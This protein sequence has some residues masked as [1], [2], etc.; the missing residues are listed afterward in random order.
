MKNVYVVCNVYTTPFFGKASRIKRI[1][2][3]PTHP[4]VHSI[5]PKRKERENAT[6]KNSQNSNDV[7]VSDIKKEQETAEDS[8]MDISSD[9]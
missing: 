8:P 7:L 3:G 2:Q 1:W 4:R 9:E 5:Y 6:A